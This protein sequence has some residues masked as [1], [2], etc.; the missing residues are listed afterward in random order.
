ML[1]TQ[2]K[3]NEQGSEFGEG[4]RAKGRVHFFCRKGKWIVSCLSGLFVCYFS[5]SV[6]IV[7]SCY[8]TTALQSV[9][10]LYYRR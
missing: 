2:E 7:F 4:E 8:V 3:D 10:S 1:L 9:V 5:V 6:V